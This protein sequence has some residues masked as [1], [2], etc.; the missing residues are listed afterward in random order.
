MV[1]C[2]DPQKVVLANPLHLKYIPGWVG[3]AFPS[4]HEYVRLPQ[5]VYVF[6]ERDKV[7]SSSYDHFVAQSALAIQGIP[8]T[9]TL[10]WKA[11]QLNG[12]RWWSADDY[13]RAYL[14][15]G[16]E[17]SIQLLPVFL[18][19]GY[20]VVHIRCTDRNTHER[21]ESSFCTLRVLRKLR[22][23]HHLV[24]VTNNVSI[25]SR[26]LPPQT[27]L[28]QRSVWEDMQLILGAFAIV[29]HASEGWSSF[30][31]VPAM[32]KEIPLINTYTGV[33]HRY[34]FFR[35]YGDLPP[36]FYACGQLKPFMARLR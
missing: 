3:Y 30:T 15:A 35:Q 33:N 22:R 4:F 12:S 7:T 36:E 5:H 23:A 19:S 20:I 13:R 9:S 10:Y 24:V 27:I 32:A 11:L 18:R 34:S 6:E 25:A 21:D 2:E 28:E 14:A 31:S 16:R 29:Q 8:Q 17:L 1:W 26:W